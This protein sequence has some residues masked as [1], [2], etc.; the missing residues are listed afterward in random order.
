MDILHPPKAASESVTWDSAIVSRG[1]S[2][3][4]IPL[5]LLNSYMLS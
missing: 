4:A 3:R 5:M 1:N 2:Y